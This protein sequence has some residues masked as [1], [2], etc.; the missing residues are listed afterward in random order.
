MVSKK[1][2]TAPLEFTLPLFL[3]NFL[4]VRILS[5]VVK[6]YAKT[7]SAHAGAA[8]KDESVAIFKMMQAS[9]WAVWSFGI[10]SEEWGVDR[11][12]QFNHGCYGA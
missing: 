2:A 8:Y 7:V 6:A 11:S 10:G 9:V 1:L 3:V 12:G 4:G 5:P